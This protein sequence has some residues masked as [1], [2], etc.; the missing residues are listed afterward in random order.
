MPNLLICLMKGSVFNWNQIV[1]VDFSCLLSFCL[2]FLSDFNFAHNITITIASVAF[3]CIR[4]FVFE[5]FSYRDT[6]FHTK[7]TRSNLNRIRWKL[8]FH[9]QK[10]FIVFTLK[11]A[12]FTKAERDINREDSWWIETKVYRGVYSVQYLI[13]P[14]PLGCIVLL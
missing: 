10:M 14:L 1:K 13:L 5:F 11:L 8:I 7:K 2:I 4:K 6:F 3:I 12:V 9:E